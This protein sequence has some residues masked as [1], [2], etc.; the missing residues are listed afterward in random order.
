MASEVEHGEGDQGV[1]GSEAEGDAGDESDLG[2]HRF[3]ATVRE[4]MLD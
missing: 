4:A 2:I 1:G 3:D